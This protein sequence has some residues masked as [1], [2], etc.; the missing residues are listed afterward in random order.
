MTEKLNIGCGRRH[1][2]GYKTID[3]EPSNNPDIVGDFRKMSFSDIEEIR[4]EHILEHFDRK[5]GIEVLKQWHSWLKPGGRLIV[6]TPDLQ[7]SCSYFMS[8]PEKINIHLYG[9][10]EADW[11]F[12]KDGWWEEK[13][14][15]V[16]P[17][18]GFTVL[19]IVLPKYQNGLPS[20]KVQA[21]KN[22]DS[23]QY[24]GL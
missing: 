17:Q 24:I 14:R 10:Q 21:V 11:A 8:M 16:L 5:E 12:H 18:I 3:I 19:N 20:I 7:R 13:F 23:K 22:E 6:E 2:K 9:S 4:A 15:K 1:L